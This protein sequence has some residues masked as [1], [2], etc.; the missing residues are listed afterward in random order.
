MK[1][2]YKGFLRLKGIF[3]IFFLL[4]LLGCYNTPEKDNLK[5]KEDPAYPRWLK[6]GNY[7][8]QQTSG[9]C[10]L[11]LD[12]HGNKNFLLVDDIGKI[13]HFKIK[14]DTAFSF[15]TVVLGE[16]VKTYLQPFPKWDFEEIIYDKYTNSVYLSIEGNN[17]E[18]QKYVGIY[19]IIFNNNNVYSDTV[20]G[21]E[22][23]NIK[24]ENLFLK[25]IANNIGYE[26]FAVD[27]NF[28]YLGL[29]GFSTSGIFADSTFL[30]IVNKKDLR[31]VRQ[32]N[33][34]P[35]GIHT[36]CGLYSD[37]NNSIYGVDR[38]NKK[39]FHLLFDTANNYA[40]K[41]YE[42][43]DITTNIPDYQEYD[44]VAALE[45]ITMDNEKN[46]YF[47]DDPWKTF[48]VPQENILKKLDSSTVENFKDFIPIIY[49]FKLIKPA[50]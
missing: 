16:K 8:T 33:T 13:H 23:L 34:K 43:T 40:V 29:E 17:P 42:L 26:G 44:Y 7:I 12:K 49:K 9:N 41:K 6:S 46:I 39:L 45:S 5:I 37:Q 14:N 19:K 20:S 10:F 30:F 3:L 31:I 38:N 18:P 27:K 15:S 28:F 21:I 48:Y 2:M 1:K 32:I 50:G 47:I 22:K 24:P 25:Y 4:I 36:I 35:F 11:G